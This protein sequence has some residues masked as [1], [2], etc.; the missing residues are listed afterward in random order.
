MKG[1]LI[2]GIAED[3]AERLELWEGV[4]VYGADLAFKVFEGYNATGSVTCNT[5]AAREWIGDNFAELG[6]VVEDMRDAW[7]YNAGGDIFNNPEKFQ[8]C[9]YLWV[10]SELCSNLP[11]VSNFWD[12]ETQLNPEL[13]EKIRAEI[14][15]FLSRVGG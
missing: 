3:F 8:V 4:S 14:N 11:T 15:D 5:Y 1:N 2:E 12:E 10:A 7:G 9:V 13:I 6:D